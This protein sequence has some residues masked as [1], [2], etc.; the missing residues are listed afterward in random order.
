[1]LTTDCVLCGCVQLDHFYV[2]GAADYWSVLSG[3]T[4]QD[5][6]VADFAVPGLKEDF[7]GGLSKP[8]ESDLQLMRAQGLA[9]WISVH[10]KA[11]RKLELFVLPE[12][13]KSA[14][15]ITDC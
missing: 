12:I 15:V 4:N 2:C 9:G 1:M 3:H 7:L 5:L 10:D 6:L 13:V 11:D 14:L 8:N